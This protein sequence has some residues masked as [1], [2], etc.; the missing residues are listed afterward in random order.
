M[1]LFSGHIQ[2]CDGTSQP[3]HRALSSESLRWAEQQITLKHLC[4]TL[5]LKNTHVFFV[6]RDDVQRDH[7]LE[8]GQ[9]EHA[10]RGGRGGHHQLRG[11]PGATHDPKYLIFA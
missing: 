8:P 5:P 10:G 3:R 1:F 2:P 11:Q 6:S 9:G 7:S 4:L